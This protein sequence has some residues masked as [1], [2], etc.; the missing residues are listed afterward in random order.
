MPHVPLNAGPSSHKAKTTKNVYKTFSQGVAAEDER[1]LNLRVLIADPFAQLREIVRDILLRGI[2]VEEVIEARDGEEA[3]HILTDAATSCDVVIAD[4]AMKPLNGLELT[5][6]IRAG[7]SGVDPF[8][9][10]IVTSNHAE[11]GEIVAARDAGATEYLAKPLSAKILDLR[12][13]AVV[14]NPRPFVRTDDFFGPDRRR[15]A[16]NAFSGSERRTHDAAVIAPQ[17]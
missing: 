13:H 3:M 1:I 5:K 6:L 9:P 12:L 4:S 17:V 14:Q 10:V 11:V 7:A 15:H 8:L 16:Q 2:G